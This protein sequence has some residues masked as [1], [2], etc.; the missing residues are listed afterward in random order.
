M[1]FDFQGIQILGI[2]CSK[3]LMYENFGIQENQNDDKNNNNNNNNNR[4]HPYSSTGARKKVQ[5]QSHPNKCAICAHSVTGLHYGV[6][7]CEACKLFF[8]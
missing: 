5:T 7:V 3:N 4:Y 8:L 1:D 2:E 6:Y